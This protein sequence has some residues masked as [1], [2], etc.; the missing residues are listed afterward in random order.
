MVAPANSVG[1]VCGSDGVAVVGST[2]VCRLTSWSFNPTASSSEW[3][4]S[5]SAGYTNVKNARKAGTGSIAGKLEVTQKPHKALFLPGDTVK[6]VLW[7][8]QSEYWYLARAH[9]NS[10]NLTFD[11]DSKEVVEWTADFASDGKYYRP[12]ESGQPTETFPTS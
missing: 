4:D 12:G 11:Q 3:G 2:R 1:A 7:E 8:S 5:D 10:Y 6:L 9:I